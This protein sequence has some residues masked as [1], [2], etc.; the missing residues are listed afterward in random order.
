MSG[1]GDD[2]FMARRDAARARLDAIFGAKGGEAHDRRS[3]FEAVY[4][5]AEGDP[6][7][8]PWADLKPKDALQEWLSRHPGEGMRA[9]DIACGLGDNAEALSAAGYRTTA[10]D[11][12]QGAVDWARQRFPGSSVEYR[13]ADLFS[14]PPEWQGAFDLVHECYTVQALHGDLRDRAYAA[15][16]RFVKPGGTLLVISRYRTEGE[17]T[18]GPPW[19]LSPSEFARFEVLGLRRMSWTPY[20]VHRPGRIIAHVIA[21]YRRD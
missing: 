13:R 17:E 9:L 10:F 15:I 1:P 11:L 19:P 12:A 18:S 8:V 14:P 6:A 16:A 20:E 21:E 2:D 4:D 5:T 7:A 3:W